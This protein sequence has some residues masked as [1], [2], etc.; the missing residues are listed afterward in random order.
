MSIVWSLMVKV[1]A[2]G[3]R[4]YDTF[5]TWGSAT[6]CLNAA[7][8]FIVAHV[9]AGEA[10]LEWAELGEGGNLREQFEWATRELA[11]VAP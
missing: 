10:R 6:E 8:P 11:G 2:R 3:L 5:Q 9:D 4:R 7:V 1:P